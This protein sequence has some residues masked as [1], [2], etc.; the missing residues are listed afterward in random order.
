MP[1]LDKVTL[2]K[3]KQGSSALYVVI[4]K[5]AYERSHCQDLHTKRRRDKVTREGEGEDWERRGERR[6]AGR[7]REKECVKGQEQEGYQREIAKE[8]ER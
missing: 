1:F 5:V 6:E 4:L 3:A 7:E 8:R 2:P